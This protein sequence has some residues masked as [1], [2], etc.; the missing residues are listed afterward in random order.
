M[1]IDTHCHLYGDKEYE[2]NVLKDIK[3]DNNFLCAI[4]LSSNEAEAQRCKEIAAESKK[5]FFAAGFHPE[6]AEEFSSDSLKKIEEIAQ[7]KKCV[8]IG[9]VGLDYHYTIDN[10]ELQKQILIEQINLAYKLKKPVCFH[11]RDAAADLYAIVKENKEKLKYGFVVHCFSENAEY[12]QKFNA[13]G[14]Y[15]GI[16]G[17]FTFKNYD[18][19]VAKYLPLDRIILETDSPYLAPVPLRGQ[20]NTPINVRFTAAKLAEVLNKTQEEIESLT[21]QNALRFYGIKIEP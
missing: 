8:A 1:L 10:K 13:L 12:A 7:D 19:S 2:S 21:T 4:T 17:N 16:C 9:E 15:F 6:N 11:C 3:E 18:V 5:V 20:T 14:A